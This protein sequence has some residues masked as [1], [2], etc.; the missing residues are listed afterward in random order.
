MYDILLKFSLLNNFGSAYTMKLIDEEN[1]LEL[2][3]LQVCLN[4]SNKAQEWA[5]KKDSNTKYM[6]SY[7]SSEFT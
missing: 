5:G 6:A 1:Y 7:R 4:A 3:L 2:Q